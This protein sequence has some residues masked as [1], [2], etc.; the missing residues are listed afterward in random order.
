MKGH[1]SGAFLSFLW[2]Q[3]C[4]QSNTASTYPGLGRGRAQLLGAWHRRPRAL[5]VTS[6]YTLQVLPKYRS[7]NKRT[8]P[9][10]WVSTACWRG[11][12]YECL[13]SR[14]AGPQHGRLHH[15][16]SSGA[17]CE[18]CECRGSISWCRESKTKTEQ[19]SRTKV[20]AAASNYWA[21]N[22][23]Q[24]PCKNFM[25]IIISLTLTATHGSNYYYRLH[26]PHK[27]TNTWRGNLT[28]SKSC[29]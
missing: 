2:A 8:Q 20:T 24:A 13:I 23:C 18:L 27:E 4:H 3:P 21:F 9:V 28:Y 6:S 10:L 26:F 1:L 15:Q 7:L 19:R 14:T 29:S 17:C 25:L 5:S 11:Q 22:I 12:G 16:V